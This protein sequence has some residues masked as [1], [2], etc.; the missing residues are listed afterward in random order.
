MVL[1]ANERFVW[2]FAPDKVEV[3]AGTATPGKD[4]GDGGPALQASFKAIK[5]LAV[6]ADGDVY[7]LDDARVRRIHAGKIG[8]SVGNGQSAYGGDGGP[9][10]QA[11]IG[12][13][14]GISV[15]PAG[16]LLLGDLYNGRVRQVVGDTIRTIA[17]NGEQGLAGDGGPPLAAEFLAAGATVTTADGV[18]YVGDN[19]RVR[20]I[21]DGVITT[22]AGLAELS[23]QPR[24]IEGVNIAPSALLYEAASNSL[25]FS[26]TLRIR[27][28]R[29]DTQMVE[30]VCGDGYKL[31]AVK[32]GDP[33]VGTFVDP[34]GGNI[35]RL[36][37][38][39][40]AFSAADAG[41]ASRI[42]E[43]REGK[44]HLVAGAPRDGNPA[45]FVGEGPVATTQLWPYSKIA[46]VDGTYYVAGGATFTEKPEVRKHAAQVRRLDA[47]GTWRVV[48]GG[49][50]TTPG[51][52][53][54]GPE[55]NFDGLYS[56]AKDPFES[57]LYV[58]EFAAIDRIDLKAG[59]VTRYAGTGVAGTPLN[60]VNG[61][62]ADT[63]PVEGSDHMTFDTAG[64]LYIN[65]YQSRTVR[66]IDRKTRI[67][68]GVAGV[69]GQ[70][71]SG[72]DVDSSLSAPEGLAFDAGG[73]LFIA[74]LAHHQI[75]R[76]PA[77]RLRN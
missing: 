70:N 11:K 45:H 51:T 14:G 55:V 74:D 59:T 48:A 71:L 72:D 63:V 27:R 47:D 30:T 15:D 38:G 69:N 54:P 3:F 66:R 68:S 53:V 25:L 65:G 62:V 37:D 41:K 58:S 32:E 61:L 50:K 8:T 40:I 10:T 46:W 4:N 56:I 57:V 76:I 28:L 39:T 16:N 19:G 75:K 36:P 2:T 31:V 26:E 35:L 29:L 43:L 64:N 52:D 6:G 5:G 49:G 44:L 42:F 73:N 67:I 1:G 23:P 13:F 33:A 60:V 20:K 21:A 22:V 34:S 24:P 9:A 12:G 17:G 77:D 18:V 7:V